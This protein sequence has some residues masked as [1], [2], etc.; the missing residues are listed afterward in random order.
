MKQLWRVILLVTLAVAFPLRTL[1]MS[2]ERCCPLGAANVQ[3]YAA[4]TDGD[5]AGTGD[6]C[7]TL[8]HCAAG[9]PSG[10]SV[11]ST[12]TATCTSAA[13]TPAMAGSLASLWESILFAHPQPPYFSVVSPPLERPPQAIA[14]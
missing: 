5:R 8:G 12:C 10:N 4:Q 13:V 3:A 6:G 1:A 7:D 14:S 9:A 11:H 2:A